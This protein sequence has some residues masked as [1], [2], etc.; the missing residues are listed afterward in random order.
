MPAG[1]R[2]RHTENFRGRFMLL[3]RLLLLLLLRQ[4]ESTLPTCMH[5]FCCLILVLLLALTM[6][7][8]MAMAVA[9]SVAMPFTLKQVITVLGAGW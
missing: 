1:L 6:A 2:L 5:C 9:M 7:T 3:L 8:V 4:D